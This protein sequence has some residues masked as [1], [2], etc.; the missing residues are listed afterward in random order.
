MLAD[1]PVRAPPDAVAL[2]RRMAGRPGL[3]VLLS[4]EPD[5]PRGHRSFVACEPDLETSTWDPRE[6]ASEAA[7]ASAVPRF[8][9]V[10]PYEA[11]RGL[12]RA[13]WVPAETRPAPL[14]GEVAWRRYPAVLVVDH[15]SGTVRAVGV[16]ASRCRDL[17]RWA[18]QPAPPSRAATLEVQDGEPPEAHEARV[19]RAIELIYAGDLYQVNLARALDVRVRVP[20]DGQPTATALVGVLDVLASRARTPFAALL[21]LEGATI[22]ST[23]PELFLDA[24]PRDDGALELV[25]EPIKGTR[26]R[27]SDPEADRARAAELDLDPKERAELSMIVDVER[28]DLSRV[29]EAASVNVAGAPRVETFSTVHHRVATVV[30]TTRRGVGLRDVLDATWPSGSVTGAPKI[31]AMEVIASLE[32]VRR[33]LYTGALGYVGYDGSMRLSMAIRTLV[34][35]AF[36]AGTY[37]TGGGITARSVPAQELEETRWK[38]AQLWPGSSE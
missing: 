20:G 27:A 23:S 32:P 10:L 31:R 16:S 7:L 8:I 22:V 19:A 15:A 29:C 26:P 34:V 25:T 14:I 18:E 9:G 38:A 11:R 28:N 13:R 37:L 21:E 5:R 2:A 3:S 36:G 6:G 17:A 30:G 24:T 12:E 4:T 35:D 33:G 1:E